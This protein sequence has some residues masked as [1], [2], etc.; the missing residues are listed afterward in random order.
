MFARLQRVHDQKGLY[1]VPRCQKKTGIHFHGIS[2]ELL[3]VINR[4]FR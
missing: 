3:S 4:T 1:K 2:I